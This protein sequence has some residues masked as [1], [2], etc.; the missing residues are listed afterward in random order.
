MNP[1]IWSIAV[2]TVG[3]GGSW[4]IAGLQGMGIY[5]AGAFWCAWVMLV[6]GYRMRR[7]GGLS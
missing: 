2:W 4:W 3:L 7:R 6:H 1:K 5:L